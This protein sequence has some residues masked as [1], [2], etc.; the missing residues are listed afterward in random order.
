MGSLHVDID[1]NA[2]YFHGLYDH[3]RILVES[4]EGYLRGCV[5]GFNVQLKGNDVVL[6]PRISLT[7]FDA[8]QD[9]SLQ[10]ADDVLRALLD[11]MSLLPAHKREKFIVDRTA[12]WK[13]MH[14]GGY[15]MVL[16][17]RVPKAVDEIDLIQGM[18]VEIALAKQQIHAVPRT[19]LEDRSITK[20][21]QLMQIFNDKSVLDKYQLTARQ[22]E[23]AKRLAATDATAASR[24]LQE[25]MN[26][27]QTE[28]RVFVKAHAWTKSRK[29]A[30]HTIDT[31]CRE[32]PYVELDYHVDIIKDTIF[33]FGPD[34][35]NW[36]VSGPT[37]Y[38]E[39]V[40]ALHSLVFREG[41][42]I[43]S[44]LL[45]IECGLLKLNL[46]TKY[47]VSEPTITYHA[48]GSRG[49]FTS[50]VSEETARILPVKAR[51]ALTSLAQR[52]HPVSDD[53]GAV[54]ATAVRV[55]EDDV[56][57]NNHVLNDTEKDIFVG[58]H[59]LTSGI[60]INRDIWTANNR[61]KC[62]PWQLREPVKDE[63]VVL[64][65]LGENGMYVS[66][67]LKVT[68]VLDTTILIERH[69]YV[70][71]G[72]SGAAI[73]SLRGFALLGIHSAVV[74]QQLIAYRFSSTH[75][76]ELVMRDTSLPPSMYGDDEMGMRVMA[77]FRKH[78]LAS[79]FKRTAS[80]I[81]ALRHEGKHV[82][83]ATVIAEN[84]IV[85][86]CNMDLP[87]TISGSEVPLTWSSIS[88]GVYGAHVPGLSHSSPPFIRRPNV[89][90]KVF[91]VGWDDSPYIA[92]ESAVA[93]VGLDAKSFVIR[94]F[95]TKAV[96]V[97]GL[98][99]GWDGAVLGVVAHD[100]DTTQIG[101]GVRCWPL[102]VYAEKEM[103]L[104]DKIVEAAFPVLSPVAW[105][106]GLLE[107]VCTHV[108]STEGNCDGVRRNN[109]ALTLIGR[110]FIQYNLDKSLRDANIPV[111]A[112][113]D[114]HDT[115]LSVDK[116]S[117]LVDRYG[118]R[119]LIKTGSS[120]TMALRPIDYADL[121][122]SLVGAASLVES[123][124]VM[125]V[126]LERMKFTFNSSLEDT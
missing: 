113:S 67:P 2:A 107:E 83:M 111:N 62:D 115:I 34:N 72:M 124:T 56:L 59:K 17:P 5:G 90:E 68:S 53:A 61:G 100:S 1:R 8:L 65:G 47:D 4:E 26:A 55:T 74:G 71:P 87:L 114:Y 85:T 105:P 119:S 98:V 106:A 118:L 25:A 125:M 33:M 44:V 109:A 69:S 82:G 60:Q 37:I 73:V 117:T 57:V 38:T 102:P 12:V 14:A 46:G 96:A 95:D 116:V 39:Q 41:Y 88:T 48:G 9:L 30:V 89:I 45:S 104:P 97:G 28:V 120:M 40:R 110:T 64:C 13:P 77:H 99:I 6:H 78:G 20:T 43:P 24:L 76:S 84:Y 22:I 42:I 3:K 92:G 23:S 15:R 19:Q 81:L 126:L 16:V 122:F 123:E 11:D 35:E 103:M 86:T 58:E 54:I 29:Q 18:P 63:L 32:Y 31:F 52:L 75:L 50:G 108:T 36:V 93:F 79:N 101:S 66:P 80:S 91:I 70:V 112:W 10:S 94:K 121:I 51:V 21:Y 49:V 7:D 27:C